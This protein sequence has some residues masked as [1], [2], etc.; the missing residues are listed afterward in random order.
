MDRLIR[1]KEDIITGFLLIIFLSLSFK[2][3]A[4]E[5]ISVMAMVV[6][7]MGLLYTRE[8]HFIGRPRL[9]RF[10]I[11][12]Y[13]VLCI[14]AI[15]AEDKTMALNSLCVKSILV[16][17]SFS[18]LVFKTINQNQFKKFTFGF[19]TIILCSMVYVIFNYFHNFE[20]ILKDMLQGHP[21]PVPFRSH[22]RYSILVN[23]ALMISLYRADLLS[24][25][26]RTFEYGLWVSLVLILFVF[27]QFLAVKVG[28]VVS[29]ITLICF[30]IHKI[31]KTREFIFGAFFLS[32]FCLISVITMS[33]LPTIK[34]K[35]AYVKY[36]LSRY[37]LNDTKN[38]SD[39]ERIVSVKKGIDIL[40]EHPWFGVGEGNVAHYLPKDE[41]GEVKLP[42]N[43]FILTW[44]Q[45]GILGF[46]LFACCFFYS[47]LSSIRRKNWLLFT[48]TISYFMACMVES[49]L[50]TQIG[51]AVFIIPW[52]IFAS[53]T[54]ISHK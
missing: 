27:I 53:L 25:N 47:I 13:L 36:D 38:F 10:F 51:A 50:E 2:A 37:K 1:Y 26:R 41:S 54:H 43:Q 35:I 32:A 30:A 44:A 45:N 24:V 31:L 52:A 20:I 14:S 6:F 8:T 4:I 22:V 28:L 16:G 49:M 46:A 19:V 7:A 17:V 5:S 34:N 48:L 40:R 39:G 23:I 42:H 29:Y 9:F 3:R 11:M 12:Y 21:I 15:W 18:F 33:K